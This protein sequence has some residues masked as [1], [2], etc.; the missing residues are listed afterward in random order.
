MMVSYPIAVRSHILHNELIRI[1]FEERH[2][3]RIV[4][5]VNTYK[6]THG[7]SNPGLE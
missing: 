1:A 4:E 7:G 3:I 2:R 6:W 5:G